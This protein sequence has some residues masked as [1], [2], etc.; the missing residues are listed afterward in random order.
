MPAAWQ[1][2]YTV[3]KRLSAFLN[4]V[5][6]PQL[7]NLSLLTFGLRLKRTAGFVKATDT[8]SKSYRLRSRPGSGTLRR[9]YDLP[10]CRSEA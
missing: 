7:T 1:A 10:L 9:M 4:L 3:W 5:S 6:N 2:Y 8:K